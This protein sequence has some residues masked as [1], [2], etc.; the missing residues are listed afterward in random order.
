MVLLFKQ[1]HRLL[2][3]ACDTPKSFFA[4]TE[5]LSLVN[6]EQNTIVEIFI[7]STLLTFEKK[8]FRTKFS[9]GTWNLES[10]T[11]LL[12]EIKAKIII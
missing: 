11:P 2:C 5:H 7:F 4:L 9:V 12:S 10:W 8:P 6:C 3:V 1:R